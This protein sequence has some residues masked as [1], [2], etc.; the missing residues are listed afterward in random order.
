MTHSFFLYYYLSII[1]TR[2]SDNITYFSFGFIFSILR[3]FIFMLCVM[4]LTVLCQA[5]VV[6]LKDSWCINA[7]TR[8]ILSATRWRLLFSFL[9]YKPKYIIILNNVKLLMVEFKHVN[10]YLQRKVCFLRNVLN[11]HYIRKLC[12][13]SSALVSMSVLLNNY[14]FLISLIVRN[15][16]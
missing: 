13:K 5:M 6:L 1:L 15:N 10:I 8:R 11:T 14:F 12:L 2:F 3:E 7:I 4:F 16:D 9:S